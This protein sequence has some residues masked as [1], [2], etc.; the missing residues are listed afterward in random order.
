M[1]IAKCQKGNSS[2]VW[3]VNHRKCIPIRP[4]FFSSWHLWRFCKEI[5][6][7]IR[8]WHQLKSPK[9]FSYC[10]ATIFGGVCW[11]QTYRERGWKICWSWFFQF[12]PFF[13]LPY[14]LPDD[15]NLCYSRSQTE[16]LNLEEE[17]FDATVTTSSTSA[18]WLTITCILH[19]AELI[20]YV[21]WQSF[22]ACR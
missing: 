6:I 21:L 14:D 2:S 4:V 18:T 11:N 12:S 8:T 17:S 22:I 10:S 16:I 7:L 13:S 19:I 5:T 1:N 15:E 3:A 9:K 20:D